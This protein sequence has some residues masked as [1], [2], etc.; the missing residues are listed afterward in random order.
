MNIFCCSR[1][2]ALMTFGQR[3]ICKFAG[4][5]AYPTTSNVTASSVDLMALYTKSIRY[6]WWSRN[7]KYWDEVIGFLARYLLYT[8]CYKGESEKRYSLLMPS[9]TELRNTLVIWQYTVRVN[10]GLCR[11]D[12]LNWSNCVVFILFV[13]LNHQKVWHAEWSSWMTGKP[14]SCINKIPP[15]PQLFL[16]DSV[17]TSPWIRTSRS[18]F[19]QRNKLQSPTPGEEN[20]ETGTQKRSYSTDTHGYAAV[21]R[22][23]DTPGF[24][25]L[26]NSVGKQTGAALS[27]F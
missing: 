8:T 22:T 27:C 4:D 7:I 5:I 6:N 9:I 1:C 24:R 11:P 23:Q 10:W 13:F 12:N 3:Y 16:S 21:R 14:G 17:M 20:K 15:L 2:K 26:R 19:T 18:H 25:A